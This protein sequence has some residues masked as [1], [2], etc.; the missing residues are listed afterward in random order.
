VL[1]VLRGDATPAR[2]PQVVLAMNRWA[3][4]F[5]VLGALAGWLGSD[6][7]WWAVPLVLVPVA[8]LP[9]LLVGRP[10]L[11]GAVVTVSGVAC[12]AAA[13]AATGLLGVPAA[14]GLG[15]LALLAGV[16]LA[17]HR[18]ALV[19]PLA[20][21]V[22]IGGLVAGGSHAADGALFAALVATLVAWLAP[23]IDRGA[24]RRGAVLVVAAVLVAAG[25]A[26]ASVAVDHVLRP[27]RGASVAALTVLALAGLVFAAVAVVV[28]GSARAVEAQRLAWVAPLLPVAAALAVGGRLIG[29]TGALAL[30]GG[31]VLVLCVTAWWGAPPWASRVLAATA[32]AAPPHG[33]RAALAATA[34]LSVG[35]GVVGALTTAEPRV[36][37]VLVAFAAAETCAAIALVAIR[38]WRFAPRARTRSAAIVCVASAASFGYAA[39]AFAGRFWAPALLAVVVAVPVVVA[40]QL[41]AL[42]D[43]ARIRAAARAVPAPDRPER[44]G[45]RMPESRSASR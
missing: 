15:V 18:G 11:V 5:A 30:T 44:D 21:L 39:A 35:G 33:S 17:V 14:A 45:Q 32:R 20:A 31:L 12:A 26:A 6:V 22:V 2:A 42:A 1:V 3:P 9:E 38:Q 41:G 29:D 8:F 10:R 34:A 25:G 23:G 28:G 37:L 19:A 16:E 4:A 24:G 36:A 13:C 7:S 40:W 43:R 27:G